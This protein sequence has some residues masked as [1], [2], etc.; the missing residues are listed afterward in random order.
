MSIADQSRAPIETVRSDPLQRV[1]NLSVIYFF[2]GLPLFGS[3]YPF[4]SFA[5][6]KENMWRSMGWSALLAMCPWAIFFFWKFCKTLYG[7]KA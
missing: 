5:Q 1:G 4:V 2:V 7:K 3:M 6:D